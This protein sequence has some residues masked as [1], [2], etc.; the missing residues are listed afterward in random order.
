MKR[1]KFATLWLISGLPAI[2]LGRGVSPYLP[3]NLEPEIETQIERVLIL[4]DKP[5]MTRPIA[6]AT[7]LDALPKAR[8]IDPALCDR[9]DRYLSRLM[10]TKG[11]ARASVEGASSSGDGRAIVAPNRYGMRED[12]K[13]DISIQAYA[14]S[15]DYV[16]LNAGVNSYE[17]KTDFT[18]SML[19]LG[20]SRVQLDIGFRPH[21]FSPMTDSSM[22]MST[23]APTMPSVTL[24]NY[25]PF[26]RFGLH[27]E[28]FAARM[29]NS[30]RIVLGD[31]LT[32]GHPTLA[33]VHLDVE[34]ATGWSLGVSRLSQYGGGALGGNS[35]RRL[36]SSLFKPSVSQ[37]AVA[38][39][40]VG[41]QEASFTSKLLF[42]GRVPFAVYF[43]YAGEDTSRGRS[44]L[45]GN[46]ALSAG[47]HFPRLWQRL[48]LTLE[49]TEWQNGWYVHTVYL[50][51]LTNYGRVVGN[52]FG[53]QRAPGDG[54]GGHSSMA[55]LGWTPPF[56]GLLQLQYRTLQNQSYFGTN[57]QRFHDISVGY[58]RPW[59]GVIV[60]GEVASG[61]D[62]Y[63]QNFS[64]LAGFIRY[65]EGQGLAGSLAE[66]LSAEDQPLIDDGEIFI[67]VGANSNRQNVDLTSASTRAN[68]PYGYGPHFAVGARR[69]VSDRSDLGARVE[70]DNIQ[71]HSLIGVRA[72][73]YRY[74]FRSPL[75][76][77]VFIGAAR[78]ALA[79]PAYGIYYGAGLQ[80]RNLLPGW[81]VGADYRYADSV[82]RDHLLPNDPP[83][84]GARSDSF[85]NI[86]SFT[87]S[88][89]RHF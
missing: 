48:D 1:A 44:W 59:L 88:I 23:E 2:A 70:Y 12:S 20:T 51:G 87:L 32:S 11:I 77:S 52:W 75:A 66:A 26:T 81:D 67:D 4:A 39:Q 43:E 46:S 57:Y 85:Y 7:V 64:R 22:L 35:L 71:G 50:D 73:D 84:I 33:G 14:Q 5:V 62:V 25:E 82:A 21:S 58:S 24:S 36:V 54:V 61:R 80:W 10:H 55:R 47:I 13:R 45:L 79:T 16:L 6:A 37:T 41:N 86:S 18:G 60:G 31:G 74:R 42:P 30:D 49:V 76:L 17:G 29:S 3:L 83:N 28:F 8:K 72:L 69:F 38:S 89:S 63:G 34:P 78:Y 56:G 27:Y 15:G 65:D 19:S 9:V 40:Q 53:D 68:G